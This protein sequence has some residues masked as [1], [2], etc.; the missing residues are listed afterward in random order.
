MLNL[1]GN[2]LTVEGLVSIAP[3]IRAAAADLEELDLSNNIICVSNDN[4]AAYWEEFL[5]SFATCRILKKINLSG[6]NLSGAKALEIFYKVYGQQFP[7]M[8]ARLDPHTSDTICGLHRVESIMLSNTSMTDAGALFLS[9]VLSQHSWSRERLG[10][11]SE[12]TV[13]QGS[14]PH[15][16][17]Y[18]PNKDISGVGIKLLKLAESVP[19]DPFENPQSPS[20]P[21]TNTPVVTSDATPGS[22]QRYVGTTKC[23]SQ[24]TVSV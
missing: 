23:T 17:V 5:Q 8:E 16:F 15:G 6:N 1:A 20:F 9:Y 11:R 4:E 24:A 3:C 14:S 13:D 22:R 2:C 19:Y 21:P 7:R 12:T 18:I 10:V